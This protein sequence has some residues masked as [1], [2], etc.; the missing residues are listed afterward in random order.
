MTP[1]TTLVDNQTI[2]MYNCP[3]RGSYW[4]ILGLQSKAPKPELDAGIWMHAVN[5][6]AFKMRQSG[7][8]KGKCIQDALAQNQ[9]PASL[10]GHPK[11]LEQDRVMAVS[12]YL[13][14]GL[15][16]QPNQILAVE[17]QISFLLMPGVLYICNIDLL[18]KETTVVVHDWKSSGYSGSR[19]KDFYSF[20]PAMVGYV[21]AAKQ[22]WPNLPIDQ[23][24]IDMIVCQRLVKGAK[25]EWTPYRYLVTERD[26]N[27][28]W[29]ETRQRV[30]D[31][32]DIRANKRVAVRNKSCC[33]EFNRR[34]PYFDICEQGANNV[35]HEQWEIKK[36]D[37]K[38]R[39][40]TDSY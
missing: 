20:H 15:N 37:P 5:E 28:W 40:M 38:N 9:W 13:V 32:L 14:D 24:C 8:N 39:C 26:E 19:S 35:H 27:Q 17:E 21:I 4:D 6:V 7:E 36:W 33:F 25:I 30:Q 3:R 2:S 29:E 11:I 31:I 23:Y 10:A 16:V 12:N 1:P 18:L 22:M 34:C